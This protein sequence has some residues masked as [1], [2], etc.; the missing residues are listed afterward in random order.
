MS[1]FAVGSLRAAVFMVVGVGQAVIVKV[2]D[3]PHIITVYQK[4]KAAWEAAGDYRG[5][6]IRVKGRSDSIA[7]KRWIRAARGGTIFP[8]K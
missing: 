6:S 3:R 8:A 1:G 7:I 2:W 5:K 4:S